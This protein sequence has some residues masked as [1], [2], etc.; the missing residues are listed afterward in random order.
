[1][2]IEIACTELSPEQATMGTALVDNLAQFFSETTAPGTNV[3]ENQWS[4]AIFNTVDTT[5]GDSVIDFTVTV[6]AGDVSVAATDIAVLGTV[7]YSI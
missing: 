3:T 1:M 6:P 7:T 5:N 2:P 4:N